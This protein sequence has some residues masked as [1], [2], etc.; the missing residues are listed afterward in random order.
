MNSLA[1]F[2]FEAGRIS[3]AVNLHKEILNKRKTILRKDHPDILCSLNNLAGAYFYEKKYSD[4]EIL[5]K[6]CIEK[7]DNVIGEYAR[8]T[9]GSILNLA[10]VYQ[11]N[12]LRAIIR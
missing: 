9:L 5:Y 2:Y 10:T 6:K 7:R 3:D 12:C 8:E 4:A 1:T 11:L